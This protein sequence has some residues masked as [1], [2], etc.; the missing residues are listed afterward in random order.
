MCGEYLSD[1]ITTAELSGSPPH[2]WRIPIFGVPS[3]IILR[4]TSTL[5]E[6]THNLAHRLQVVEDHLHTRGEYDLLLRRKLTVPGSPPHSWRIQQRLILMVEQV[7]ITSTLVENTSYPPNLLFEVGITSTLV[8][9][10][11]N[12]PRY[13][14]I[15]QSK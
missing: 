12:D 6:N 7:G 13:I 11:L 2:S 8:E 1:S 15:S 5:V 9:N 3:L 4:I 10:T 14:N